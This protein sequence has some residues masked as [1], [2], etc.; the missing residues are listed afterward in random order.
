[1]PQ[2]FIKYFPGE[3]SLWLLKHYPNAYLL[4]FYIAENA[5]CSSNPIDNLKHSECYLT[6]IFDIGE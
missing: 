4:L 5:C 2:G 6:S 3:K 1:M